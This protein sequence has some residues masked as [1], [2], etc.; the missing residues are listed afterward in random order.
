VAFEESRPDWAESGEEDVDFLTA[1]E[2]AHLQQ[3]FEAAGDIGRSAELAG[4][5]LL[6]VGFLRCVDATRPDWPV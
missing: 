5:R 3:K 2:F 1:A 6:H 4:H